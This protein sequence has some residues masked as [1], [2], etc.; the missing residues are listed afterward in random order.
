MRTHIHLWHVLLSQQPSVLCGSV[1]SYHLLSLV[2]RSNCT[3]SLLTDGCPNATTRNSF[4]MTPHIETIRST[5]L[6]LSIRQLSARGL[7]PRWCHLCLWCPAPHALN[8]RSMESL[9][10]QR[11]QKRLPRVIRSFRAG[12]PPHFQTSRPEQF[13]I[14]RQNPKRCGKHEQLKVCTRSYNWHSTYHYCKN[15][16]WL[17]SSS[18]LSAGREVPTK[19]AVHDASARQHTQTCSRPRSTSAT[20]PSRRLPC[21]HGTPRSAASVHRPGVRN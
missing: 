10:S 6:F 1:R 9:S 8:H 14:P 5:L 12:A 2:Q 17:R 20:S 3:S 15:L 16:S 19:S 7:V 18:H 13:H 4:I 11:S 21:G